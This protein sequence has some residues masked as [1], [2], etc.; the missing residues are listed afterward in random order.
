[1]PNG[2][3]TI[4]ELKEVKRKFDEQFPPRDDVAD[5]S[6]FA[7]ALSNLFGFKIVPKDL[8]DNCIAVSPNVYAALMGKL[9]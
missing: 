8:P 2:I 3:L 1:M 9:K 7:G 4:E 5:Y 6:V